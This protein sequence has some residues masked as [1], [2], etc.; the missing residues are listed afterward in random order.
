MNLMNNCLISK[1]SPQSWCFCFCCTSLP[2]NCWRRRM[3]HHQWAHVQIFGRVNASCESS[4]VRWFIFL[5]EKPLLSQSCRPA[6]PS[7]CLFAFYE[8]LIVELIYYGKQ[9]SWNIL[10]IWDRRIKS[11]FNGQGKRRKKP[12]E[13]VKRKMMIVKVNNNKWDFSTARTHL[14]TLL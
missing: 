1:R 13:R 9:P 2:F 5:S 6:N 11:N 7:R 14:F 12:S 3:F 10:T 8:R 4:C